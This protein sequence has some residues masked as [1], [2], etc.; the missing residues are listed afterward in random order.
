[1]TPLNRTKIVRGSAI[2][3]TLV[4]SSCLF[5]QASSRVALTYR[6]H[7]P[8]A[9]SGAASTELWFGGLLF[10]NPDRT[11]DASSGAGVN[12]RGFG[13][14]AS[15]DVYWEKTK[16]FPVDCDLR[17][18]TVSVLP[19]ED[20]K[21]LFKTEVFCLKNG[22]KDAYT[23]TYSAVVRDAVGGDVS[24]Q[25]GTVEGLRMVVDALK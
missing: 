15:K 21:T 13:Q 1:M 4:F 20:G 23:G 11:V 25:S 6:A 24:S 5:A 12:P 10:M 16:D 7:I 2:V 3:F 18:K 8:A 14:W 22:V 9:T 17:V 19:G